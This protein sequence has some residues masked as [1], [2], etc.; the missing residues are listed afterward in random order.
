M[1]LGAARLL[2]TGKRLQYAKYVDGSVHEIRSGEGGLFNNNPGGFA[3]PYN[4]NN[5]PSRV[6]ENN[7]NL[8]KAKI[9]SIDN[10]GM[11]NERRRSLLYLEMEPG[12]YTIIADPPAGGIQSNRPFRVNAAVAGGFAGTFGSYTKKQTISTSFI[13]EADAGG[14]YRYTERLVFPNLVIPTTTFS[15]PYDCAVVTPLVGPSDTWTNIQ[16]FSSRPDGLQLFPSLQSLTIDWSCD[17]ASTQVR[18]IK[19]A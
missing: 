13:T 18:I 16:Q 3:A 5:D 8:I 12:T 7:F 11:G 10:R 1:A 19:T 14:V 9:G 17:M 2:F 6:L 4:G 15:A